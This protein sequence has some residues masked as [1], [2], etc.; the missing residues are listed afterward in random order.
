MEG[1]LNNND[2]AILGRPDA[3][4]YK[5][6]VYVYQARNL[7]GLDDSGF[8]NPYFEVSYR[9]RRSK[10]NIMEKLILDVNVPQPAQY[11][12]KIRCSC[13]D[14]N[15]FSGKDLIGRF[16]ISFV[17]VLDMM[18]KK[19][20]FWYHLTDQNGNKMKAKAY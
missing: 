15:N 7:E 1:Q 3:R 4:N 8:S 14:W 10:T 13:Y 19:T 17:D 5:M 6:I 12:P 9:G 20:P 11:A 2:L 18:H 16:C